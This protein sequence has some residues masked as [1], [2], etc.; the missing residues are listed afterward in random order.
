MVVRILYRRAFDIMNSV[1]I[2]QCH[3]AMMQ[4]S[5]S[6]RDV[7][8]GLVD[9]ELQQLRRRKHPDELSVRS[10][11]R[12]RRFAGSLQRLEGFE[13]RHL[14]TDH[15]HRSVHEIAYPQIHV[16]LRPGRLQLEMIEHPLR[17]LRQPPRAQ[18]LDVI[19]AATAPEIRQRVCAH[20]GIRIWIPMS[21][22]IRLHILIRNSSFLIPTS[23]FPH[24]APRPQPS[25]RSA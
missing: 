21:A 19:H 11:H 20:N 15:R 5:G 8:V 25:Y 18:R 22:D 23:S 13:E 12:Q 4:R 2:N 10:H 24:A 3:R 9:E 7:Q 17:L 6:N 1:R 16:A 14:R